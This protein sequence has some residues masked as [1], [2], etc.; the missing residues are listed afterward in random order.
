LKSKIEIAY[1]VQLHVTLGTVSSAYC[2]YCDSYFT[3]N[4]WFKQ[5]KV[6]LQ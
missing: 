6:P 4:E 2:Y 5:R 1:I 3:W